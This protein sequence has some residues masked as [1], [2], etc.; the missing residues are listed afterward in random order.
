[1]HN[2]ENE[3]NSNS[4]EFSDEEYVDAT[5]DTIYDHMPSGDSTHDSSWT[6]PPPESPIT[7]TELRKKIQEIRADRNMDAKEKA[8]AIQRLMTTKA[9]T[10]KPLG[11]SDN[12]HT[13]HENEND[14]TP[15]GERLEPSYQDAEAGIYGCKHYQRKVKL[16]ANCC[17]KWYSCRFCHDDVEDHNL[18]RRET[19]NMFCMLCSEIQPAA[20]VCRNCHETVARYYC[21]TCKLWDDR[22]EKSIYHCD[23]CGICRVGKGLGQDY[24]HC[25][26]C[27]ICMVISLKD[28]HRCIERSLE[29]D[30]PIC[31]EY[32]FTS[33][34]KIVFENC[35]H[36][37][38]E[39][40]HEEHIKTSY[41]CPTCLKSLWDMTTYFTRIDNFLKVQTM[42]Q[43]YE[44]FVSYILCNDCEMKS[45]TKYHFLY[46]KCTHCNGYNTTVLKTKE[47]GRPDDA[48][49]DS[50]LPDDS[51]GMDSSNTD[52]AYMITSQPVARAGNPVDAVQMN[53][54]QS[55]QGPRE[56]GS[57]DSS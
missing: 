45:Q 2:D 23:Q 10:Q 16:Q 31:G 1:M 56:H 3:T 26:K 17:G 7:Q 21:D 25:D 6:A 14:G 46:H 40:C 27:N 28:N 22:S 30:C 49:T 35:G 29:C 34:S 42:P 20:Q 24:F 9:S 43:E 37:I 53:G 57:Q 55:S 5:Y 47:L 4:D 41:Q 15:G 38:H 11:G 50:V 54:T 19:K 8:K 52:Q 44:N 32:M 51:L 12:D 18:V 33:T 48:T 39:K 13:Q 36:C